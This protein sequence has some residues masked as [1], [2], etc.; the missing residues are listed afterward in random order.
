MKKPIIFVAATAL[1][2]IVAAWFFFFRAP[3]RI[4]E[5][6][7]SATP[8]QDGLAVGPS[9][10]GWSSHAYSSTEHSGYIYM[11]DPRPEGGNKALWEFALTTKRRLSQVTRD[12]L[13]CQFYG[14]N[15]SRGPDV[16]GQAWTTDG[17][18]ILVPEGQI[19]FARLL[20]DRSTV[21]VIR[22]A[23]Q[24]GPGGHGTMQIEYRTVTGESASEAH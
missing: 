10:L 7:E 8:P 24:G 4:A 20:A 1:I 23:R 2:L 21:Y 16:F 6:S 15:D 3:V 14:M 19:F 17:A 9:I 5:M 22:L 13:R 11:R 18:A 12:D